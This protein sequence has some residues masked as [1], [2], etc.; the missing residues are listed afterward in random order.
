MPALVDRHTGKPK[1]FEA[2]L[3]GGGIVGIISDGGPSSLNG[4][5]VPG[6]L[7]CDHRPL[8]PPGQWLEEL[9]GRA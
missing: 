3:V 6:Q 5:G 4:I 7:P 9:D 8:W 1:Y 2:E